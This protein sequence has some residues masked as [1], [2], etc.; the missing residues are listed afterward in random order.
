MFIA[1]GFP[2]HLVGA[3]L[4]DMHD[5][6]AVGPVFGGF[7]GRGRRDAVDELL[8]LGLGKPAVGGTLLLHLRESDGANEHDAEGPSKNPVICIH[9]D[10]RALLIEKFAGLD[11]A[12]QFELGGFKRDLKRGRR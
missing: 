3:V 7:G 2:D 6:G 10:G 9:G 1:G 11:E 12:Y 4:L 5:L 8:L